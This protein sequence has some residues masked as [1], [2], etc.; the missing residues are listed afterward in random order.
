[1]TWL[2]FPSKVEEV[3]IRIR[4]D[5][6]LPLHPVWPARGASNKILS[7]SCNSAFWVFWTL[8]LPPEWHLS[9]RQAAYWVFQ[10]LFPFRHPITPV[11]RAPVLGAGPKWH[12]RV[13]RLTDPSSATLLPLTKRSMGSSRR[14]PIWWIWNTSL[15]T[16]ICLVLLPTGLACNPKATTTLTWASVFETNK[17]A[18]MF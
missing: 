13:N 2:N 18:K 3:W 4:T 1:M 5:S 10:H 16:A 7:L 11:L 12:R 15:I 8:D 9:R 6:S 14:P 17:P